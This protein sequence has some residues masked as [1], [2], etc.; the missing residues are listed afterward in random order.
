MNDVA[1][2][3]TGEFGESHLFQAKPFVVRS[4]TDQGLNNGIYGPS[5]F[6]W[7]QNI[8]QSSG[9]ALKRRD[10]HCPSTKTT[11]SISA[12]GNVCTMKRHSPIRRPSG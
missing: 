11:A 1:A 6:G 3:L 2:K 4:L 10:F 7:N 5:W 9:F 8:L 12:S